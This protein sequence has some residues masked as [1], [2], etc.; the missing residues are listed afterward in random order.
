MSAV[1]V[2]LSAILWL[3]SC[4]TAV[5][6]MEMMGAEDIEEVILEQLEVTSINFVVRSNLKRLS[7]FHVDQFYRTVIRIIDI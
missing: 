5:E 2:A 7:S 3:W 6:V 4:N 1:A